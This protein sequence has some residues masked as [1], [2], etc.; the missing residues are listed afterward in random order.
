MK[1]MRSFAVF[2]LAVAAGACETL[3]IIRRHD[4]PIE[5]LLGT[6]LDAEFSNHQGCPWLSG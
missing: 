1:A 4:L 3:E 2:A 5:V 6:W